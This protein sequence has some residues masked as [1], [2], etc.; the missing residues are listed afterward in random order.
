MRNIKL[1]PHSHDLA[2]IWYW[3]LLAMPSDRHTCTIICHWCR[4]RRLS[5]NL[6]QVKGTANILVLLIP[7]PVR[8]D[9]EKQQH[10]NFGPKFIGINNIKYYLM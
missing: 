2:N 5:V 1:K 9:Q 6:T 7:R 4:S 10:D 8:V 3:W